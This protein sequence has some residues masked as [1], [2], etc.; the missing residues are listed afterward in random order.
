MP[1]LDLEWHHVAGHQDD[2]VDADLDIW[3][4]WNI[5]MDLRAKESRERVGS[6]IVFPGQDQLWSVSVNGKKLVQKSV[7][8]LRYHCTQQRAKDYWFDKRCIGTVS[9][10]EVSWDCIGEAMCEVKSSRRKFVTK[11]S[12]G[13]CAV[14]KNTTKWNMDIDD[15]CPRCGQQFESAGHVWRCTAPTAQKNLA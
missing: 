10:E 11:H 3:A 12:S 2:V 8:S 7:E 15:S 14:N 4:R 6:P 1:Q 13:W 9:Y 5:Q